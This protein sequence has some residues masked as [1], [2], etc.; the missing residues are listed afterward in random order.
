[1]ANFYSTAFARRNAGKSLD[2]DLNSAPLRRFQAVVPLAAQASADVGYL[3][4]LPRG[5]RFA[6]GMLNTDTS[7]GAA[8]IAIGVP[9]TPAKYR[10]AAAFT[11]TDTPTMFGKAAALAEAEPETQ[12]IILTVGAAALPGAGTLIV[13]VYASHRG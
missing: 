3:V 7:L 2:G 5:Y 9:G 10:A 13:D 6:H 1:M 4:E 8:T 12:T 11:A